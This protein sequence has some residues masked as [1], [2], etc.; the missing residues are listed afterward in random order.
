MTERVHLLVHIILLVARPAAEKPESMR[1]VDIKELD[2]HTTEYMQAWF[3]DRDHP[4]N[5]KKLPFLREIFKV[6]R[7]YERFLN[8][9]LGMLSGLDCRPLSSNDY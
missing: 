9:E 1:D 2:A 4:E 3:S 5:Q 8:G 6:A 7:S